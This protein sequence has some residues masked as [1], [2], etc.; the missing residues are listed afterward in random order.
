MS[1]AKI[2]LAII[3]RAR[4]LLRAHAE[5]KDIERQLKNTGSPP[6]TRGDFW[7]AAISFGAFS[8]EGADADVSIDLDQETARLIWP[9]IRKTIEN[10]IAKLG[11]EP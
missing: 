4:I 2:T 11:V 3:E 9:H 8:D 5:F 1:T 7:G 10:E 6:N